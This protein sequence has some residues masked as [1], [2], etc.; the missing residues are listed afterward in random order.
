MKPDK[1][2]YACEQE[3]A[4]RSERRTASVEVRGEVIELDLPHLVCAS[5]GC[6]SVDPRAGDP[7]ELAFSEYRRRHGL[8]EPSQIKQIRKQWSLSQN[9]FAKLLGMSPAT[10][11]RYESGSVQEQTH[12]ELIRRCEDRSFMA[13]LLDR[14][15]S[16]LSPSERRR[17]SVSIVPGVRSTIRDRLSGAVK[18]KD[19]GQEVSIRTGFRKFDLERFRSVVLRLIRADQCVT[20]TKLNK[21]LF[22]TDFLHFRAESVS[23][24][25]LAY[26][27][28]PYGPVPP[29]ATDLLPLLED[30]G[31][32]QRVER[33]YENGNEGEEFRLGDSANSAE[34]EFTPEEELVLRFVLQTFGRMTP[35]RVSEVSHEEAAWIETPN[36]EFISYDFAMRLRIAPNQ[37]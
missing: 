26:R 25:G 4:F 22:Y 8:L 20:P 13:D 1:F 27:R 28:M 21:L 33:T 2:C 3:S 15:G 18:R 9:A 17:L 12:D 23:L 7:V 34:V 16:D 19:L 31:L 5:C 11:S 35:G 36:R 6:S 29:L 24:T 30:D 14:H 37:Q 10:I 32:I